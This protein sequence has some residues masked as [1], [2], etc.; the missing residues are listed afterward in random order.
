ME[1]QD[2][3]MIVSGSPSGEIEVI[4][5]GS[6]IKLTLGDIIQLNAPNHENLNEQTF[7]IEYIDE[8]QIILL[9][10][11]NLTTIQLNM[12][13]DG[14]LT[15]ESIEKI[16][17]LSHSE[18]NGY[19]RQNNLL[20]QTWIDI[21]I[22][23]EIPVI[24]TGQI[25]NLDEDMIEV[26]TYP[27]MDVIYIDFGYKGIP[28]DI[29]FERFEIRGKPIGL[30]G[31]QFSQSLSQSLQEREEAEE[32]ED[33]PL[34]IMANV[35]DNAN[36]AEVSNEA[37]KEVFEVLN[38]MYLEAD[39]LVF[40]EELEEISQ[41]VEL[42]E[43]QKRYGVEIQANDLMDELLAT[44]PN[45][46]RTKDVLNRVH[47]LIE[48]FKQLRSMFSKFDDNGNIIGFIQLG[49][50][51]KPLVEHIRNLDKRLSWLVPAV[52]QQ[53][54]IYSAE[55]SSKII[56][57]EETTDI[58]DVVF[59][60]LNKEINDQHELIKSYN[61]NTLPNGVNKYEYLFSK[62][63]EINECFIP[64]T[65]L[66]TNLTKTQPVLENMDVIINN[67]DDF[68]SSVNAVTMK[69]RGN[70]TLEHR[71]FVIQRYQ[72]GM[73]KKNKIL[74][75]SGK[76]V[77]IRDNMTPN[78]KMSV[79]SIVMLPEPAVKFSHIH[80][81]GTNLFNKTNLHQ[82][83][84]SLFRILH[85]KT[86]IG[87]YIVDN[88]DKEI[89][90]EEDDIP[91]TTSMKEAM[92][93]FLANYKEFLLENDNNITNH[94]QRFEKF[95]NVIIPKT[96][97]IF[98]L[99]QK[100]IKDKLSL[101]DIVKE[102]EPFLIYS[103]DITYK[104][105]DEI[106]YFVKQ[107][108]IS[109]KEK[110]A[111][112]ANEYKKM[113]KSTFRINSHM[114][115]I[116]RI[117]FDNK[118]F[119]QMFEDGYH[120]LKENEQTSWHNSSPSELLVKLN[121]L[122][123]SVL[124]SDIIS[125]MMMKTLSTPENI[126]EAFEPAK[127]DDLTET[128]KIKANDC[129]RRYLAKKYKN[130]SEMRSD[131]GNEDVFYD[132]ELDSWTAS[133]DYFTK[134]YQVEKKAM[135]PAEFLE[136]LKMNL[137]H[138]HDVSQQ[139][140][141]EMAKAIIEGKKR[142]SDGEYASVTIDLKSDENKELSIPSDSNSPFFS[143]TS[144][145]S[146]S[147][148]PPFVPKSPNMEDYD[149]Y[150]VKLS[151]KIQYYKRVKD[152][153]VHDTKINEEA[154]IDTSTLFCNINEN[155]FKDQKSDICESE[156]VSKN[157]MMA[158]NKMRMKSEFSQR[159]AGSIEE[160]TKGIKRR[161]E[162]DYRQIIRERRLNQVKS[163]KYND[164]A[165]DLGKTSVQEEILE[166]PHRKLRDQ[167]LGQD[168]FHKK[169]TDIVKFVEMFCREPM[170]DDLS[171][172]PAWF[173]CRDTN[174][175]I[176]PQSL[177]K[178]S[179][180]FT[181]GGNY[182]AKLAE[183]CHDVGIISDDGDSIVDK[184]TGYVLRKID[185]VTEDE[186]TEEGL[187]INTHDILE[188]EFETR[189]GKILAI[190]SSGKTTVFENEQNQNIYNITK[191]ICQQI[192]IPTETVQDFV[193][194]TTNE[195]MDQNIQSEELYERK[196]QA[197]EKKKGVRPIPYEIYKNRFMF[198]I[199][200]S[201][202]L[203]SIQTAIPSFRTKKTFPG[204][205]RSFQGYPLDGG[206]ED[207][208][209]IQYIA[210]VMFKIKSSSIPWNSIERLNLEAYTQKIRETLEKIILPNRSDIDQMYL[211]KREYMILHPDDIIPL[212]HGINRWPLFLPPVVPFS[213]VSKLRPITKE[214]EREMMDLI[215]DGHKDQRTHM[216]LMKSRAV[217]Y[218]Y[219]VIESI[220]DVIKTKDI[221]LKTSS[222]IPFLENACC[223]D[224]L[225][226]PLAYFIKENPA[227][228]KFMEITQYLSEMLGE[229]NTLLGRPSI[230]FH[231]GFTG[232]KYPII[233][234]VTLVENIYSA[235]FH[236]C[237]FDSE[238][239]IPESLLLI[240][241]EKPSTI[242]GY[243]QDWSMTEKIEFLKMN[244][245]QY[246]PN[247]LEQLMTVVRN[248]NRINLEPIQLFSQVDV[249]RDLLESF[250]QMDS[251]VIED[252]FRMKMLAVIDNF[253]P[254]KMVKEARPELDALKN[255]VAKSNERMYYAIVDFMDKFG[256]L[257]DSKFHDFQDWLMNPG[258]LQSSISLSEK[259]FL[260]KTTQNVKNMVYDMSRLFPQMILQ[261][262]IFDHI[263]KHWDLA[264]I[265]I[266]DL[267]TV[268][269]KYWD[270]I[271][272]FFGDTIVSEI[273]NDT[274]TKLSDI[275]HMVHALPVYSP[276][277]K[278][279]DE[280][281]SLFDSESTYLIFIYFLYSTLYEYIVSSENPETIRSD[282]ITSKKKRR[283]DINDQNDVA[284]QSE[285]VLIDL[286]ENFEEVQENLEEI[287]LNIVLPSEFKTRVAQMLLAFINIEKENLPV[288]LSYEEI[289]KKIGFS[290]KQEKKRI[291]DYLG[292]L[293]DDERKIEDQFKQYK[294]GRW[295][296]GM[297]KGLVYYDKSTY[298]R[299]RNEM[300]ANM[301]GGDMGTAAIDVNV[302]EAEEQRDII[303]EYDNEGKQIG[304]YGED[305]GDGVYYTEDRDPDD[306]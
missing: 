168:D 198:W 292:S 17:I 149:K 302:L 117:M 68:Y 214:F 127:L 124:F 268:L 25:T 153:W 63:N 75:R 45:S 101:V 155:C 147:Y 298:E 121:T 248:R 260:Y 48:R 201:T 93:E 94:P 61:K 282:I 244:G 165:Y 200:A 111:K 109:I 181:V 279:N 173:Y 228:A 133:Y 216:A 90:Y 240:C 254:M 229:T 139:I 31:K 152:Q 269:N 58:K 49:P 104:Q 32:D 81:P 138:K 137:I 3:T 258:N 162:T 208:T 241:S 41:L 44:I 304:D 130:M 194:F 235:F 116:Q 296:A 179:L 177:Y 206:I 267:D 12:N 262:K 120:L 195:L 60:K 300:D 110:F 230:L 107:K 22:G 174:T 188:D 183:I 37:E 232:I 96:R 186:F 154:F 112:N 59:S 225:I 24:I 89:P 84:M 6:K 175:T 274:T 291:T 197:L 82:H 280:Y 234:D 224:T 118:D 99:I 227:I 71:R 106:R 259:D 278:G 13:T 196:A 125:T 299:E 190:D 76:T 66:E 15:D 222:K 243:K 301:F 23:G 85:K 122:D 246:R 123:C 160:M 236:Y 157:R 272:P 34:D 65:D 140:A 108:L 210:C 281:H 67:F 286:H 283:E 297:Q 70:D 270:P 36:I 306:F 8:K 245:K 238:I 221:L 182:S 72:M 275:F 218:G 252:I 134:M 83:Y 256:N 21:H 29:P 249:M 226:E 19:A 212:E 7:F 10:V 16:Y 20:P 91:K 51:H 231:P 171:E 98:R 86:D 88:L 237:H 28:R 284:K 35:E 205:V 266:R 5:G 290:K 191:S 305:Y 113:R 95:L 100:Y 261:Q 80:L 163:E 161:L 294:M 102:L 276:I 255:Y 4:L 40:G 189:L 213:I 271:R 79:T 289:A 204:C 209:G 166:S 242:S 132:K 78:D 136:F 192:G 119:L 150:G 220:N 97:V 156:L 148:S 26:T 176:F 217:Q 285:A 287:N 39:E 151:S 2:N 30:L 187:H 18:E 144:P 167:V 53:K 202:I 170:I 87:K 115:R 43:T 141:E 233:T 92:P 178:L 251:P 172:N 277:L 288:F 114:N 143:P 247:Q 9:D 54:F 199:I 253:N 1:I 264:S 180:V 142:V 303:E 47:G 56:E 295:N 27:E 158:L 128:E 69:K 105:Y 126:L 52:S 293:K 74:M 203:I 103:K 184:Y 273:L 42:P 38:S 257:E 11:A 211:K 169:Q 207:I 77:H 14:Y 265:H 46:R 50:L 185:F 159:I 193:L 131:N 146:D 263:P 239:P 215:R 164:Y 250:I 135:A 33:E 55:D 62:L 64:E 57:D 129:V 145:V 73:S 219:A 223:H